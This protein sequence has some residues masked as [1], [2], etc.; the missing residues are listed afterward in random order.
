[1]TE[2][3]GKIREAFQECLR[4]DPNAIKEATAFLAQCEDQVNEFLPI[5]FH[6]SASS[7]EKEAIRFQSFVLIKNILHRK[8][9]VHHS[10]TT[11]S[12][13]PVSKLGSHS[14]SFQKQRT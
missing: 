8:W 6:F 7:E 5:L 4:G 10:N 1:M 11:K 2:A 13:I 3:V 9:G 14:T 12:N